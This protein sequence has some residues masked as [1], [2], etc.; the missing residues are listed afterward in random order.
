[1]SQFERKNRKRTWASKYWLWCESCNKQIMKWFWI[2]KKK[3]DKTDRDY[4][5][6]C[7]TC[8][9][10]TKDNVISMYFKDKKEA[11][12]LNWFSKI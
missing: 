6:L 7:D 11:L 5:V 3:S 12:D 9:L 8:W 10:K 1:M 4:V 2:R